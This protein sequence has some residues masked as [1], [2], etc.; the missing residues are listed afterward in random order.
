MLT[1]TLPVMIGPHR[2]Q[3]P[4]YG[5]YDDVQ[6]HRRQL[7]HRALNTRS[8][9]AFVGA[10]CS[11]CQGYLPWRDF[12]LAV[13]KQA[14]AF[15]S[16]SER[17]TLR[18]F[19]QLLRMK[20]YSSSS[21]VYALTTSQ[22][23]FIKYNKQQQYYTFIGSLF[24]NPIQPR[25]RNSNP[26]HD[27]LRLPISR[28]ITSNYDVEMEKAIHE[29]RLITSV[30]KGTP[31]WLRKTSF[32][33]ADK[34]RLAL[35]VLAGVR[36]AD[37]LVFHCH[38]CCQ[39]PES[40]VVTEKDYREQYLS[41]DDSSADFQQT[42][43]LLFGSNPLLFVGY[44]LGDDDLLR[45]LRMFIAA[46]G[47]SVRPRPLFALMP[48]WSK[49]DQGM[50]KDIH[51]SLYERY[52]INIITFPCVGSPHDL[53][54]FRKGLIRELKELR[55]SLVAWRQDWIKKPPVRAPSSGPIF[56]H[57]AVGTP[58]RIIKSS[59]TD[60][61]LVRA[62]TAIDHLLARLADP[63]ESKDSADNHSGTVIVFTGPGGAGKSWLAMQLHRTTSSL[64]G[65]GFDGSFFWSSYYA[66]DSLTGIDRALAFLE[67][68]RAGKEAASDP[69]YMSLSRQ[70]R[71]RRHLKS[72]RYLLV[73][74]GVERFLRE[75]KNPGD[76][77]PCS[78]DIDQFFAALTDNESSS[79]IVLTS[80]LWPTPL[81]PIVKAGRLGVVAVPVGS[82][83]SG[84]LSSPAFG[85]CPATQLSELCSLLGGHVYALVLANAV[86]AKVNGRDKQRSRRAIREKLGDLIAA[87]SRTPP[88]RRASRMIREALNALD[89]R[90]QPYATKLLEALSVFASPISKAVLKCCFRVACPGIGA[91]RSERL[92]TNVIDALKAMSL[93]QEV[94]ESDSIGR[95]IDQGKG[96]PSDERREAA[97]TMHPMIREYFFSRFHH[98]GDIVPNLTL[99]GFT[100][101]AA[102]THPLP[103]RNADEVLAIFDGL[104]AEAKEQLT[105]RGPLT[106]DAVAARDATDLCR[107]LFSLVRSRMGS[108]TVPRWTHYDRYAMCLGHLTDLTRCL[109]PD[110]R[111]SNAE[112]TL[113]E[114]YQRSCGPLYADEL[115]WLYNELGLVAY[116]EGNLLD[117]LS[118]WD[119]GYS[120]NRLIDGD[121]C[122]YY[123]TQSQ[124]NLGAANIEYGYLPLA[125]QYL[126]DALKSSL[127]LGDRDH[128]G[129]CLGYLG[130]VQHLRGNLPGAQEY[131]THC[132]TL[133]RDNNPRA[134]SIFL[135]HQAHLEF[136]QGNL[137]TAEQ[138]IRKAR[139]LAEAARYF[140]VAA[141][142]RTSYGHLLRLRRKYSASSLEYQA[143]IGEAR[144]MGFRKLEADVL[145]ELS[146]LALDL[147]DA[148][149]ARNRAISALKLANELGLGIRKTHGLVVLGLATIKG[150]QRDLGI[151]YLHHARRLAN[152]QEY[153]LRMQEAEEELY[154]EGELKTVSR[155]LE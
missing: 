141:L 46:E 113:T 25:I 111:W 73:F 34:H 63:E 38:G 68:R 142:A 155:V 67:S 138:D 105:Q 143:A 79:V 45:P 26:Y 102:D 150:G 126:R 88:D 59:W 124:C 127:R 24:R 75:V 93:L 82:L 135:L 116:S 62:K 83:T 60:R 129:R 56:T 7:L 94:E 96:C 18:R 55:T 103:K 139:A 2:L 42:L 140:D 64:D 13:V 23:L 148:E 5:Q 117:A 154:K 19:T 8:L 49:G 84:D 57:H 20:Q 133:V 52:G 145:S 41:P 106:S 29:C 27:L 87:L 128:E 153:W 50:Q 151:A 33:Q 35:F 22:K 71:L 137:D 134:E 107:S 91:H 54:G 89:A 43:A 125:E 9:V 51:D 36:D 118:M 70:D 30:D 136:K 66:D 61:N 21:L 17:T 78:P 112:S 1:P 74:D 101:V 4:P 10:G 16:Q 131:Y 99:P 39:K 147:G 97:F 100:A 32:T 152:Q 144:R 28:F 14:H 114:V 149:V 110:Q 120:I 58:Q 108:L 69:S 53:A 90:E 80:R 3:I 119:Q 98:T 48:L 81:T 76:G 77:E 6:V 95:S 12:A 65:P 130:L 37:H 86:L 72:G 104:L 47:A 123:T 15:A 109:F 85:A 31:A 11:A 115:A 44:G 40:M 92:L 132:L 146:R 122:G 121:A